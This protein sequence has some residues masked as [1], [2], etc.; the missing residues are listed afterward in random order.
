MTTAG[1]VSIVNKEGGLQVRSRDRESIEAFCLLSGV[2]RKRIVEGGG[3]DY[4]W[5]VRRVSKRAVRRYNN[6]VLEGITYSNFKNEAKRVRG[7]KYASFLG[8]VWGAGWELAPA[9]AWVAYTTPYTPKG[10]AKN[11]ARWSAPAATPDDVELPTVDEY[12]DMAYD[13]RDDAYTMI[14]ELADQGYADAAELR[15]LIDAVERDWT[16]KDLASMTDEEFAEFE[17]SE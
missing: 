12:L 15:D 8:R 6:A 10:S 7:P 16:V 5:R 13:A 11:A 4:Q 2:D 3:T 17:R 9:R 1:F 14:G